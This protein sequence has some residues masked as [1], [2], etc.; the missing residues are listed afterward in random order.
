MVNMALTTSLQK[1]NPSYMKR[2]VMERK[3]RKLENGVISKKSLSTTLMNVS[4]NNHW[5][6]ISKTRS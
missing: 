4:Q 3:R 2:R 1:T 5:W 6:S